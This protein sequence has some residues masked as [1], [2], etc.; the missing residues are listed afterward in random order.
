MQ[1]NPRYDGE[2][3]I[4]LD[5]VPGDAGAAFVRQRARVADALSE[6][7]PE[8]WSA[9]TRCEGWSVQDVVEHLVGV[10]RFWALS[11]GAGLRGEPTRV[12]ATFDPVAVPAA[13][14]VAARGRPPSETL[15]DFASTNDELAQLLDGVR[16]GE[17]SLAA[18][19]PPGH[20]AIRTVVA[21]GLWDAWIH[22]RDVLLPL[23]TVP[24]VEADEVMIA[25][26]Y[27]A[28]LGPAFHCTTGTG[29]VA[30]MAVVGSDPEV[31]LTL[32]VG[33]SVVVRAGA[34]AGATATVRGRSVDLLDALS[35]RAPMPEIEAEHRWL[36]RG[37]AEAFEPG[38][39]QAAG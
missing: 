21:H 27:A 2:P 15:M 31:G 11:I 37:L 33:S 20:L 16:D 10:N 14:V 24:G 8:R 35:R 26:A 5:G 12:L 3:V 6:L 38:S 22:E 17:W 23:G 13:M 32:D 7:T 39:A 29:T 28:A 1:L 34:E 30:T 4:D 18:E 25:L 19:A 9:Q 36:L